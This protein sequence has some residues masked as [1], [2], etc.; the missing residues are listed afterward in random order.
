LTANAFTPKERAFAA[1]LSNSSAFWPK[2]H[3]RLLWPRQ[4]NSFSIPFPA[5]VISAFYFFKS[6]IS[7]NLDVIAKLNFSFFLNAGTM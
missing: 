4:S 6:V 3:L 1:T 5:P 2:S 7:F